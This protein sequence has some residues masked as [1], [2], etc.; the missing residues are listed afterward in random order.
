MVSPD[1]RAMTV[2][3]RQYKGLVKMIPITLRS[4][5]PHGLGSLELWVRMPECCRVGLYPQFTA[6]T[7]VNSGLAMGTFPIQ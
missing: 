1:E 5:A 4:K 3:R 6:L 7:W 2:N